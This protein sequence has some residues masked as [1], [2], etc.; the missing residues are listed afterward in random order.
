MSARAWF[1]VAAL[2]AA[3]GLAG[4]GAAAQPGLMDS[5]YTVADAAAHN[6]TAQVESLLLKGQSDPDGVNGASGRTAL[7]YAVSFDNMTMAT[8]LL[9][10]GAHVDA[11]D[12]SGD[13]AL[14]WAAELGNLAMMRM[15]I[16]HKATVD[17]TNR[18]GITPLMLAAANTQ[19][20]AVRLLI[21]RGAD[22]TKEDF[23]G[24]DAAGWAAGNPAVVAALD[25]KK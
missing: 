19:P 25:T 9:A 17:A 3:F 20:E 5:W 14:H 13:T 16:A 18:Q 8:F 2:G 15:L 21:A 4:G 24:R 12:R 6:A 11:R 7:D 1:M 23:T 10:H 22:P